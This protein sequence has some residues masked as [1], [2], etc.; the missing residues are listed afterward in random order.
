MT[1]NIEQANRVITIVLKHAASARE[2]AGQNGRFDDGGAVALEREAH[3]FLAGMNRQW[4]EGWEKYI[5]EDRQANDPD[6]QTFIRLKRIYE[7]GT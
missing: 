5:N 1:V 7:P 3:C 6:Y 4:P 2:S